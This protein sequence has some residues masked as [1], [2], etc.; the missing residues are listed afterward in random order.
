MLT[1]QVAAVIPMEHNRNKQYRPTSTRE[2]QGL[3]DDRNSFLERI[4]V[5]EA[6]RLGREVGQTTYRAT[7]PASR[8]VTCKCGRDDCW[9]NDLLPLRAHM[10]GSLFS[11]SAR[12]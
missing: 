1:L 4:R 7:D 10:S 2:Y 11:R 9:T 8:Y 12:T 6:Q 5:E 3:D